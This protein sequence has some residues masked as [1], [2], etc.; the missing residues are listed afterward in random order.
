MKFD[1]IISEKISGFAFD[2]QVG[3]QFPTPIYVE[4][5][6]RA[7]A[8]EAFEAFVGRKIGDQFDPNDVE[9]LHEPFEQDVFIDVITPADELNRGGA[10][11]RNGKLHKTHNGRF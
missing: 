8:I 6:D 3:R 2:H 11:L 9:F 4:G 7:A 1:G 10:I 5:A